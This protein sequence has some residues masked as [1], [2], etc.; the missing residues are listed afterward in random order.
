MTPPDQNR[1]RFR[2][3]HSDNRKPAHRGGSNE[4]GGERGR[5]LDGGAMAKHTHYLELARQANPDYSVRHEGAKDQRM[6][7]P[8]E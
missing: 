6:R 2:N 3:R 7:D 4:I 1:S 8:P 5:A